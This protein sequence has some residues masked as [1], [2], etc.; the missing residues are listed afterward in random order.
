M[1][2]TSINIYVNHPEVLIKPEDETTVLKIDAEVIV[3]SAYDPNKGVHFIIK[4]ENGK[5]V[6]KYNVSR[7]QYGK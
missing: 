1:S 4:D 6:A 7:G 5:V 2:K 3:L